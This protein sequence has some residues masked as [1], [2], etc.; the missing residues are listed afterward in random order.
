MSVTKSA[1]RTRSRLAFDWH[2]LASFPMRS[3]TT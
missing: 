1:S 2:S 3:S